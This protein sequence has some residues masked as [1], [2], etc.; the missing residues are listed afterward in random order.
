M[1]TTCDRKTW[2]AAP[3]SEAT[4]LDLADIVGVLADT[5]PGRWPSE[6]LGF[7]DRAAPP[8]APAPKPIPRP[9]APASPPPLPP[10]ALKLAPPAPR[11]TAAA[12]P[13]DDLGELA[14][15][16]PSSNLRRLETLS[17]EVWELRLVSLSD[18]DYHSQQLSGLRR[19]LAW[20]LAGSLLAIAAAGSALAW[21]GWRLQAAQA[22]LSRYATTL[23]RQQQRLDTLERQRL[24]ELEQHL[25]AL[26]A[27][28]PDSLA[29]DWATQQASIAD[30]QRQVQNLKA[31]QADR[32][33]ALAALL[34][35]IQTDLPPARP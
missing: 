24:V 33:A 14:R 10:L 28:L 8:P 2:P 35:A 3:A 6:L 27:E 32:E 30:L 29:N 19:R 17:Q 15:P 31:N 11:P 20:I 16:T 7:G 4:A 12:A 26:Q 13:S 34:N 1:P 21:T 25:Q 23:E 9:T 18:G 22:D 5:A